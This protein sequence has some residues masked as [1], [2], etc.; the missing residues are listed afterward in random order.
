MKLFQT[1]I[2]DKHIETISDVLRNGDIGFG[3]NVRVLETEF[4]KFSNR[5]FNIAVNSASAASFMIFAYLKEKYGVCD[6]YTPSIGFT[7]PAWA[8]KHF[9]HNIIWVEVD[10][11]LLFDVRDYKHRREFRD[12]LEM[13]A[14]DGFYDSYSDRKVVIMPILYGGVSTI[15]YM[16]ELKDEIVV[17]DSAHCVTPT[18]KSDFIFFSFHPYKPI[19]SS[20]GGM[21]S[22]DDELASEWFK[23]YRNFGRQSIDDTYDISMEGFKFYMNNLNATIT[24]TQMDVYYDN[25]KNRKYNNSVIESL[26]LKGRLL[27]HDDKSSYYFSTLICD[28]DSVDELSKKYPTSKHYPM[29]HKTTYF[30]NRF[31]LP[32]TENIHKL[33]LNLPLYDKI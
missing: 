6:V 30:D 15:P 16:D 32:F 33:I 2:K 11:N 1:Q 9:G 3:S 28:E 17:V 19:A 31:E 29:L 27:P 26:N 25:L 24:L 4:N 18:I 20:D 5:T 7:S 10:E 21:I 23:A 22:T 12:S 8:A 14:N 13:I